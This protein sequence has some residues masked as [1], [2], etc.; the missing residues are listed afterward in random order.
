VKR[1]F[2][3]DMHPLLNALHE[4]RMPRLIRTDGGARAGAAQR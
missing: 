2:G 1:T 3:Y 4:N